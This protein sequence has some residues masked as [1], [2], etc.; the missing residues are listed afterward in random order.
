MRWVIF[1]AA[2]TASEPEFAKK[3]ES[4]EL[5]GT[6]ESRTYDEAQIRFV[7]C[8]VALALALRRGEGWC[9]RNTLPSR[10]HDRDIVLPQLC[11]MMA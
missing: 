10:V 1:S 6:I 3:N 7:I 4:N 9:E 11:F 5:C 2:S 8:D